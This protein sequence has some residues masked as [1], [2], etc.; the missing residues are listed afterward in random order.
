VKIHSHALPVLLI[1][2]VSFLASPL[3][4]E[5]EVYFS[6]DTDLLRLFQ[7]QINLSQGSLLA[8]ISSIDL[9][10]LAQ[11]LVEAKKRGVK[12]RVLLDEGYARENPTMAKFLI[13]EGLEVRLLGGKA[14]GRMNN[15]FAI[16][17]TSTLLTGSYSWTER[18]QRFNLEGVLLTKEPSV[19]EAYIKEFDRLVGV[20]R[21]VT[22]T[23]TSRPLPPKVSSQKE[24]EGKEFLA[25]SFQ[26]LEKVF[27]RES[28]LSS[29]QKKQAWE[30]YR[31]KYV[32][33]QGVVVYKGIGRMD[34]NKVGIRHG[35]AEGV[36]VEVA[37]NWDYMGD[38]LSLK[39]GDFITYT[40][41]FSQ[42]RGYGSPYRLEDGDLV[43]RK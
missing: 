6:P 25:I 19:V 7:Q 3:F 38:I 31:G 4:G 8:A 10:E 28:S 29:G 21:L 27:G 5:T 18:A 34:W 32:T 1:A 36:D 22:K 14:G 43:S 41:R 40:A 23:A 12:V 13:G 15:N 16:F 2:T 30:G 11:A 33:W 37:F 35:Q 20:S 24:T 9:G 39:E 42:Q 17:D 26:E